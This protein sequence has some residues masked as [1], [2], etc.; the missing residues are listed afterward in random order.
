VGLALAA[1]LA[2]ANFAGGLLAWPLGS[3]LATVVYLFVFA[4]EM[5]LAERLQSKL[6]EEKGSEGPRSS[7]SG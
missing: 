7:R 2:A 5:G 6:S 1:A 4:L 3:F